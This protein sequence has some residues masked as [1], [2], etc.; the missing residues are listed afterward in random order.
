MVTKY[1]GLVVSCCP[2][3]KGFG[4]TLYNAMDKGHDSK[5][6][7]ANAT[8]WRK[9]GTSDLATC[10]P[11]PFCLLLQALRPLIKTIYFTDMSIVSVFSKPIS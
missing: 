5:Q 10:V 7:V 3:L 6:S 9:S 11:V 1:K 2:A 4:I 8:E